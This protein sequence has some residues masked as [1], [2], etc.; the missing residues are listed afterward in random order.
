MDSTD[1]YAGTF[2]LA[3]RYTWKSTGNLKQLKKLATGVTGAVRAIEATQDTDG[4]TWAKPAWHVK[5]LMDQAETYAGLR[6]GAEI[7]KA[8]G[9]SALAT[10]ATNDADRLAAGVAKLWNPSTNSYDWAVHDNG[11][12]TATNWNIFYPDALQ[13]AWAV[14]FGLTD[15][16][17][18][19]SLMQK[20]NTQFPKWDAPT[21]QVPYDNGLQAVNYRA[22][23]GWAEL[24]INDTARAATGAKNIRAAA[25]LANR[26]W[27]F[28]PGDAGQLVLLE[29]SAAGFLAAPVATLAMSPA[30]AVRP[31]PA[32]SAIPLLVFV[33]LISIS[34]AAPIPRRVRQGVTRSRASQYSPVK[35]RT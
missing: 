9:N 6:A 34:I 30:L 20:F 3:A 15:D 21:A 14:A 7:A 18:S 13:Q 10:R 4:L 19:A 29:S 11:A 35:T 12:H 2:L 24:R 27:P 26:A 5:Y 22:V 31:A 23:V 16:A 32:P 17:R 1:S 25:M 33:I 8:I 28:T